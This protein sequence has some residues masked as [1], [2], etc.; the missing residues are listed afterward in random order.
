LS[1]NLSEGL[2]GKN[3]TDGGGSKENQRE[4]NAVFFWGYF[5]RIRPRS[6]AD[7]RGELD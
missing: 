7:E 3:E 5:V 2:K 1:P 4:L 6:I